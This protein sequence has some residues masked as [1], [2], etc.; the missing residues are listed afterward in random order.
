MSDTQAPETFRRGCGALFFLIMLVM[1]ALWGAGLSVFIKVLE[2]AQTVIAV[3][4]E[5][6]PKI[7]SKLYS[8][9]G[10]LLGEFS[11]E[12]RQLV[13]L[14]DIPLH[15][16]KAFLATEDGIF[17]QHMGV[18]P[19]AILNSLLYYFQ[20]GRMR[21]ASTITMQVVRNV[22]PLEIGQDVT[23]DRKIREA[24]VALQVE[25]HFTKDEILELYLNQIFLGI[26]AYGVE[27]AAHQYF[28]KSCAETTLGEAALLAGI[29]RAPNSQNPFANREAALA[30]RGVVL[31]QMLENGFIS[32][33]EYDAAMAEDMDA[34]VVT[35]EE[36]LA[37][38][39]SG[40]GLWRP[41]RF[42]A[43]YF[44]EEVRR[45][46]L[47]QTDKDEVFGDG[48]EV[49]TTIDMRLQ[50]A[51]EETLLAGL[52]AF[53][54]QRMAQLARA[55][56]EEEFQ[57]V[58]GALV[59]IDNREP[60]RGFIR[61]MVG[62]RD[63]D[64]QKYNTVTQARRQPGSSIK[65]FVWT[66]A[67]SKGLTPSSVEVDAP[68]VRYDGAGKAWTPQNFSGTFEGPVTLRRALEKSVNIISIKLVERVGMPEVR[69]LL[70]RCGITTPIDDVVGLTIGLGTPDVLV[71]DH[72]VAYSCFANEGVRYD[73]V[74]ITEIRN[75]DGLTRYDYHND[76]RVERS[77][78]ANVAYVMTHLLRGAAE[79]GTGSRSRALG[80]PRAGKTGTTNENRNV[81]FCGYTPDFTAVVWM[82]YRDNSPLGRGRDYTGGRL[83]CPIWTEFMIRAHE[84]L[85]VRDFPVPEGVHFVN[86]E[87]E[88]GVRGGG[89]REAFL[90][91]TEPPAFQTV[92]EDAEYT[93]AHA[94][95]LT[96][97]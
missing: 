14:T 29:T 79:Y 91:G 40:D 59:C 77:I 41:N 17:Y 3:L 82:G 24:I 88:S 44:A 63:F 76:Q 65:P 96:P 32:Q 7:G 35:P 70:R 92:Y 80:R 2:D 85:P 54:E 84:G 16:Q 72:C 73:P 52:E 23:F 36:R 37:L 9:D 90:V 75:R 48:L 64:K 66:V 30:R 51:A 50:R 60:Y 68:F 5:F 11:E 83:A 95:L 45:L 56:K 58:S 89:W 42:K 47:A 94:A 43:P 33:A 61:A 87:R 19:D 13:R 97:L 86:V 67:I 38:A 69:S 18:R 27:A 22:E 6:R 81:W 31:G 10:E 39:A 46:L 78:P 26:S 12:Q 93:E 21:G 4:E 74:M 62:G 8:W 49:H 71:L 15:L 55:G 34:S 25:R 57:P 53:D 1:G 20:T 28:N